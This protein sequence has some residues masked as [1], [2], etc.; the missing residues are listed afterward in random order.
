MKTFNFYPTFCS[1]R[2]SITG[3]RTNIGGESLPILA[4]ILK[5]LHKKQKNSSA[6]CKFK[7]QAVSNNL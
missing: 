1:S 3:G 7:V 6:Q 4:A 2:N 5:R